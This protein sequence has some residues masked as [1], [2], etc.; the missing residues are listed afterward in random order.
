MTDK[1]AALLEA[2]RVLR[3]GGRL[4]I[5][6]FSQVE[7]LLLRSIYDQVRKRRRYILKFSSVCNVVVGPPV[8]STK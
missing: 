2:Y 1:Q 6:E 3:K 4:M 8:D 5:M 7:N